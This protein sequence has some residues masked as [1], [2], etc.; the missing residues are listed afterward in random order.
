MWH[1]SFKGLWKRFRKGLDSPQYYTGG[2]WLSA[3]SYCGKTESVQNDTAQR[4]SRKTQI[5]HLNKNRKYSNLLYYSM[6]EAGLN[7][8]TGRKSRWTVPGSEKVTWLPA[9]WYSGEIDSA[10]YHTVVR[11]TQRSNIPW[12]IISKNL[13]KLENILTHWSVAQAG[14]NDEKLDCPFNLI[15]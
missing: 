12:K 7:Y 1:C 2:D 15:I 9:V 3:V 6:A 13:T 5:T 11:L 8:K 10:L 14:S 4:Q